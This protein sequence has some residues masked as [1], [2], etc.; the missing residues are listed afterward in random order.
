MSA[1]SRISLQGAGEGVTDYKMRLGMLKARLPRLV[2]RQT[3][4]KIIAQVVTFTDSGDKV[5]AS[6][7][8]SDLA[9]FGWKHSTKSIPRHT[10]QA[11]LSGQEPR[12]GTPRNAYLNVGLKTLTKGSRIFAVLKGA[13]DGGLEIPALPGELPC[14]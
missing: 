3:N 12:T 7:L 2:V 11:C 5:V 4:K 13:V 6:A 14:R 9:G 1:K 8:S 10:L